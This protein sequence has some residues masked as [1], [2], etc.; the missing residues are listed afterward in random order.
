MKDEGNDYLS[1]PT[2]VDLSVQLVGRFDL[3]VQSTGKMRIAMK[4]N[5]A[6]QWDNPVSE[7]SA[8]SDVIHDIMSVSEELSAQSRTDK[9]LRVARHTLDL[10]YLPTLTTGSQVGESWPDTMQHSSGCLPPPRVCT[11]HAPPWRTASVS[12]GAA[13]PIGTHGY[14]R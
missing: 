2:E 9:L 4:L 10:T 8:C 12:G 6:S 7:D 3:N 1:A 14:T 5:V 11:S 13:H